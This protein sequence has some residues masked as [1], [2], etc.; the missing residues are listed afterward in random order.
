MVVPIRYIEKFI[1]PNFLNQSAMQTCHPISSSSDLYR[2]DVQGGEVSTG[3]D[4]ESARPPLRSLQ[5]G[6]N[7][8]DQPAG[9]RPASYSV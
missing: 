6:Q 4:A 1:L 9:T 5:L 8:L 2:V 7:K 3:A